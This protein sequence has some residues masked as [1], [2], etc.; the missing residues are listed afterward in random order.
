MKSGRFRGVRKAPL[1]PITRAL[2]G[3]SPRNRTH[4]EPPTTQP[5]TQTFP[6]RRPQNRLPPRAAL[7]A[8]RVPRRVPDVLLVSSALVSSALV[9]SALVSSA[10]VTATPNAESNS[11]SNHVSL[12]R[13]RT[14]LAEGQR[15][16]SRAPAARS[17]RTPVAPRRLTPRGTL[18]KK[19]WRSRTSELLNERLWS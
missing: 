19:I 12:S 16:G 2:R 11:P 13:R 5:A 4:T 3:R 7:Q 17:A 8:P 15:L 14:A 1:P 18:P 9:T 6:R 10:L